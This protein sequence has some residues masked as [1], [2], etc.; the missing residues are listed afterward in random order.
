M[1]QSDLGETDDGRVTFVKGKD[2]RLL[3]ALPE[4]PGGAD[5]AGYVLTVDVDGSPAWLPNL[6]STEGV[7]SVMER[8]EGVE[9]SD[10][11]QDEAIEQ[12]EDAI[13]RLGG[14]IG[15]ITGDGGN[16]PGGGTL[17]LDDRYLRKDLPD[18]TDYLLKFRDG[19]EIGRYTGDGLLDGGGVIDKNARA[20]LS[21][22]KL[23]EFLEVPEFRFNKIDVISG[24]TWNTI[25]YGLIESVDIAGCIITVK[26][27][28]GEVHGLQVN[29]LCRGIWHNFNASL[30]WD[31]TGSPTDDAGFE[32]VQGF[33]TSYFRVTGVSGEKEVTYELKPGSTQHPA[34]GMKFAVFGHTDDTKPERQCSVYSTRTYVRYLRGVN[35]WN[36]L[37]ENITAQL[38]DLSN[39]HMDDGTQG[40]MYGTP[41]SIYLNNVYFGGSINNINGLMRAINDASPYTAEG[42]PAEIYRNADSD[43]SCFSGGT[44]IANSLSFVAVVRKGAQ[45]L[46]YS[47]SASA[48]KFS[49]TASAG[50]GATFNIVKAASNI[51]KVII[52]T[53]TAVDVDV[54]VNIDCE[55]LATITKTL[56]LGMLYNGSDGKSPYRLDLTNETDTVSCDIDGNPLPDVVMPSTTAK[57]YLGTEEITGA[58]FAWTASGCAITGTGNTR[59]L[60]TITADQATVTASNALS[61][62][63]AV[64]T[65]KKLRNGKDVIRWSILPS[66]SEIKKKRDG[67]FVPDVIE[68][69]VFRA[70]GSG[71]PEPVADAN[72]QYR[73]SID[74]TW[75]DYTGGVTVVNTWDWIEFRITN[76]DGTATYERERVLILEDGDTPYN[77][78]LTDENTTIPCDADEKPLSGIIWPSTTAKLY[79]GTEEITGATFAWTASGCTIT[80]TGSTRQLTA[81]TADRATVTV[82]H[83]V[84]GLSK[85]WTITKNSGI[86]GAVPVSWKVLPSAT[87]IRISKS[88]A[89]TPASISCA[90]LRA[91]G[92]ADYAVTTEGVLQ[93]SLDGGAWNAYVSPLTVQASWTMLYFRLTNA[94]G[95]VVYDSQ[96]VPVLNEGVD[97]KAPL[98]IYRASVS[99]PAKP[100][101]N[102][103]APAGWS[104]TPVAAAYPQVLWMSE[105]LFYASGAPANATNTWSAPVQISGDRGQDGD[106]MP[107]PAMMFMGEYSA[108]TTYIGS[109][110]IIMMV[111]EGS[112]YYMTMTT[113][114]TLSG[115]SPG[116]NVAAGDGTTGSVWKRFSGSFKSVATELLLA[117]SALIA[118]WRFEDGVLKSQGGAGLVILDGRATSSDGDDPDNTDPRIAIGKPFAGRRSAPFRVYEDGTLYAA[119]AHL[120]GD[121]TANGNVHIDGDGTI[122]VRGGRFNGFLSFPFKKMSE[123]DVISAGYQTWKLNRDVNLIV[124]RSVVEPQS[125]TTILLPSD[126]AYNGMLV[127][128]FR[129]DRTI[130]YADGT[131]EIRTEDGSDFFVNHATSA[132]DGSS[133]T[134]SVYLSG[135]LLQFVC[136][137]AVPG[138]SGAEKA[139]WVLLGGS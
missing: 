52:V 85:V 22:L 114:G 9:E 139:C 101:D 16:E 29:D 91:E 112:L 82:S 41:G 107:G 128:I 86:N 72:L 126:V 60:A 5:P 132:I 42:V 46:E 100:A 26:L 135:A 116:S 62:L 110:E 124:D 90:K 111:K 34:A 31:G 20:V 55:G 70:I 89:I 71:D 53:W 137:V 65:V 13:K 18:H 125:G 49:I 23:R 66:A 67:A 118:G 136:V 92:A 127:N 43:A 138:V 8:L 108:T 98:R 2:G 122:T 117:E 69:E 36:V 76:E 134:N 63:S 44:Y 7:A 103:A 6:G 99:A 30:N 48:G 47:P 115:V 21:S 77:L 64:M 32:K 45:E 73:T 121:L 113:S 58:T 95:T 4:L 39:L 78:V 109:N 131:V 80:G 79:L 10:A 120:S 129:Y 11:S 102:T 93:Y 28:E 106:G 1:F 51:A 14:L 133:R 88:G 37:P 81:I 56:K 105:A 27:E 24:E 38:G 68:C 104:F 94:S 59:R 61:G 74:Q 12:M 83:A 123:S 75:T 57:L 84:S 97:G 35:T 130:S 54:T 17:T 15:D 40:G 33:A 119:N 96:Q 50:G 3:P 87:V 25:A 19:I